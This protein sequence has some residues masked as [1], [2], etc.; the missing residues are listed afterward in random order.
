[1]FNRFR[2]R[3]VIASAALAATALVLSGCAATDSGTTTSPS[4]TSGGTGE[5]TTPR[6]LSPTWKLW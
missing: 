2:G 1:M 6:H 5:V 3:G 4:A